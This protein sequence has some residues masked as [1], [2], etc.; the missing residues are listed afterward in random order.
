MLD[1]LHMALSAE[2]ILRI[3]L[4]RKLILETNPYA[5]RKKEWR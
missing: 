1:F 2:L 3:K 5:Q 4:F